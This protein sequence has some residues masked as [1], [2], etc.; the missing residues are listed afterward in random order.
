MTLNQIF[1]PICSLPLLIE[2]A[3]VPVKRTVITHKGSTYHFYQMEL[4]HMEWIKLCQSSSHQHHFLVQVIPFITWGWVPS[5]MEMLMDCVY[6][7]FNHMCVCREKTSSII[8]ANMFDGYCEWRELDHME[9][10]KLY[11]SSPHQYLFC[12]SHL[13]SL[14]GAEFHLAWASSPFSSWL[15]D[16]LYL[17]N[18]MCVCRGKTSNN[19]LG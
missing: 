8:W 15:M 11:L 16:C 5:C 19:I 3:T 14:L 2:G 7:L 13:H 1:V 10:F 4:D 12:T 6:C 17:F 18:H 9:R